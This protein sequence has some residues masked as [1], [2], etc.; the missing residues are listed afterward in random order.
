MLLSQISILAGDDVSKGFSGA[1][2]IAICR[3]AALNAIGEIDEGSFEKPQI[4]MRH[5][6][7]SAKSTKPRTT[8]EMLTFY[9][10]FRTH[11]QNQN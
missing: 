3:D 9:R 10:S 2:I 7:E 4:C 8:Q 5:L 11:H 6:I 1:E